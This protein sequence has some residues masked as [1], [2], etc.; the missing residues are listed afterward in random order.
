MNRGSSNRDI[1]SDAIGGIDIDMDFDS[2]VGLGSQCFNPIFQTLLTCILVEVDAVVA[3][4]DWNRVCCMK[5]EN[6][7]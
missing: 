7:E 3:E 6:E 4:G 1:H 2:T 5:V